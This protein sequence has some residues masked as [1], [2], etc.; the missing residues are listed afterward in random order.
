M[1]AEHGTTNDTSHK[2][3]R[4]K[5]SSHAP[6]CIFNSYNETKTDGKKKR[7]VVRVRVRIGTSTGGRGKRAR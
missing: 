3:I 4:E 2:V 6:G 1:I 5:K 7:S